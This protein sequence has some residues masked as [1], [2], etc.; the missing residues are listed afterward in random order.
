MR[1]ALKSF[2]LAKNVIIAHAMRDVELSISASTKLFKYSSVSS[3]LKFLAGFLR[4]T[5]NL[6]GLK[7]MAGGG[8]SN[9]Q[10]SRLRPIPTGKSTRK[11]LNKD[12]N[13]LNVIFM[14]ACA[15]I[16]PT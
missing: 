16:W 4:G 9:D 11:A 1:L 8:L 15:A 10:C 12:S 3:F 14:V 6:G 13:D 5:F 7:Y 2:G